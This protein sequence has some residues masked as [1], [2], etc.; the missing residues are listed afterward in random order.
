MTDFKNKGCEATN[1]ANVIEF[2]KL[3]NDAK[4]K[5]FTEDLDSDA[6]CALAG[7]LLNYLDL[8]VPSVAENIAAHFIYIICISDIMRILRVLG[9]ARNL[10]LSRFL[11]ISPCISVLIED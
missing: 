7:L 4:T 6:F 2:A 11:L 1:K 9:K 3:Q 10:G 5:I 8:R